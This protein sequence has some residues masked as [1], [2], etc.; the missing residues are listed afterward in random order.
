MVADRA[1]L[2]AS[3]LFSRLNRQRAGESRPGEPCRAVFSAVLIP[4]CLPSLVAWTRSPQAFSSR[5]EE[6]LLALRLLRG[7]P[8]FL[9]RTVDGRQPSQVAETRQRRQ[10]LLGNRQGGMRACHGVC[11]DLADPG[12]KKE[13]KKKNKKRAEAREG[14]GRASEQIK[15]V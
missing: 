11:Q 15:D 5:R 8:L 6:Q 7:V 13:K 3:G 12:E 14:W 9:S 10:S 1:Y 2:I 4:C